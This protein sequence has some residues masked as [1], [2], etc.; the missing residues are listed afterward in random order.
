[1][2]INLSHAMHGV[3]IPLCMHLGIKYIFVIG[4][5]GLVPGVENSHFYKGGRKDI[6]HY[7]S[8]AIV[9]CNKHITKFLMD[10]FNVKLYQINNS[11]LYTKIPKKT[12]V[13]CIN[14]R[15]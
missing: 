1:M 4:W 6:S 13:E 14:F 5:D 3:A 10:N 8:I 7:G 15:Y 9:K 11:S 12:V 2:M